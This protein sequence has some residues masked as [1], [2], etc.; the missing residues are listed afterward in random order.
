MA[1]VTFDTMNTS[2]FQQ[3]VSNLVEKYDARTSS[4][5]QDDGDLGPVAAL[6]MEGAS[7][8][9]RISRPISHVSGVTVGVISTRFDTIC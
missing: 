7:L 8:F 3:I 4:C 9:T 1:V 5:F 6:Y 2:K